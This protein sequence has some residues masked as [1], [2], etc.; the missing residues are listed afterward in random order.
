MNKSTSQTRKSLNWIRSIF[1]QII[2][3]ISDNYCK[4]NFETLQLSDAVMTVKCG[5]GHS[6]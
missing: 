5:K 4:Y 6:K 3:N 1:T 2:Y